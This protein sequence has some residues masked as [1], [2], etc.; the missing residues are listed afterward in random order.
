VLTKVFKYISDNNQ[1][2][3]KRSDMFADGIIGSRGYL[4]IRMCFDENMQGDV[5]I[6]NVNPKNVL[7]DPDA[8]QYDPDT[9]NEVITTKWLTVDEI[10]LLYSKKDAEALKG[11]GESAFPYGYDSID[12]FR[13][14][15]A[16][17]HAYLGSMYGFEGDANVARA[18]G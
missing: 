15:F 14:R 1:L 11:R 10:A 17:E 6:E 2:E 4:D 16:G 13:D 7:V 3:W 5:V 18:S 8:D 12:N 9:W